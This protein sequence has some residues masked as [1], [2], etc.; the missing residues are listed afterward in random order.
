MNSNKDSQKATFNLSR[1][2]GFNANGCG[3]TMNAPTDKSEVHEFIGFLADSQE[4]A[5]SYWNF[6][7]PCGCKVS[8]PLGGIPAIE[9]PFPCGHPDHW[10]VRI[11]PL[12]NHNKNDKPTTGESA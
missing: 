8:L 12:Q 2:I 5:S 10:L 9:T 3:F 6:R 7:C 1:L 11:G 4:T